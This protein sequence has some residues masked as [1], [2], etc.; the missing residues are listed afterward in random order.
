MKKFFTL[1][2][3]LMFCVSLSYAQRYT[4]EVFTDDEITVTSDIHYATN[5]TI[6]ALLFDPTVD[7][8]IPEPLF[9]D[10]YEPDQSIDSA[11][12]RPVV[13][14]VHG[15]DALPRLVNNACWGDK[16]DSVTVSTARKLAR[17]GFVAVAPNYRLGWNPLTTTQDLFLDGLVDA[18]V[19]IQQDMRACARFLRRDVEE[20]GNNYNIH[21]E[22]IAI[23]GTSSSAGTY[24]GFAA[25]INEI[26]ELQ[27][28][29]F[30]VTDEQGNIYNTF[31]EMEAG[32]IDGTVV[33]TNA[34]GDTTNYVNHPGYSSDFQLAAL[35]SA[36]S[37][38]PGVID[39]DE[40]PLIMFGNP[41][42]VVTMFDEGPIQ[43]PT[44][45]QVVAIVQLSKGMVTEAFD[46]GINDEW[47]GLTDDATLDQRADP[48]FGAIEGWLPL[49]GDPENEYPWVHW[50]EVNCP[51]SA[52]SFEVLP[53][54]DRDYALS[55][56]DTMANYF[57]PRACI[58]LDLD[59]PDVVNTREVVLTEDAVSLSPN[60]TDGTLLLEAKFG[61]T[62]EE[63]AIYSL[64]GKVVS[65]FQ[66]NNR[67]F[68]SDD[69][70]LAAGFY[71]VVVRF[72]DGI[73]TKKL[74]VR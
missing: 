2:F 23:W 46:K 25:Y 45:G 22:K 48:F 19:R 54:A 39:E 36:I 63:V 15:G 33:G 42:S 56:I 74:I 35:G 37:L 9:M 41:L 49:Y 11:E 69:L 28:P 16:L 66:V 57:G 62:I 13:L 51:V 5:A 47:L 7:E 65:L 20:N 73:A 14:V 68:Q 72:E 61:R 52:E 70:N 50:D 12:D 40:P 44:T 55:Q 34:L 32:N 53:G 58:T 1:L 17:M 38:D 31:N 67:T 6:L 10:V 24:S 21:P 8:F 43:L 29:T 64:D 26:E 59:C 27:T 71:S 60:P 30:F 3:L 4:S 18:G